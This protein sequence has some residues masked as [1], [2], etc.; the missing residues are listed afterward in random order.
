M[1]R[2]LRIMVCLIA[3]TLLALGIVMV[4]SASA[5]YATETS[6]HPWALLVRHLLALVLG[7]AAAFGIMSVPYVQLRRWAKPLVLMG[8]G[9]LLM[10]LLPGIGSQSGGAQRWFRLGPISIQP[11]EVVQLIMVVYLADVLARKQGAL[12]RFWEGLAPILGVLGFTLGLIL[13]QPDLGTVVAISLVAGGLFFVTRVRWQHLATL[14]GMAVPALA[15]LVGSA[16]YRRRRILAFLNPWGDPLGSGFQIIQSLIAIGSGGLIGVGLGH[17]TQKLF[18]LPGAYGDFIFAIIGEEL[19]LLGCLAVVGLFVGLVWCGASLALR[20]TDLFGRL[21]A[22][23]LTLTI[24][25]KALINLAVATGMMPTKGLPLPLVS[26][27]GSSLII[28]LASVGLL[29]NVGKN[30]T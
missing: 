18:Y 11:S 9:L 28:N 1:R 30:H 29:L 26:Y 5:L 27:G 24:G 16:G 14:G 3:S 6:G 20:T 25:L 13:L 21:L 8:W 22:M 17:S 19:G 10:V 7:L 12:D 2:R 4:Y 15:V 23:G